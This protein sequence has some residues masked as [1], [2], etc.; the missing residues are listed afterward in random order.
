MVA[1][2]HPFIFQFS[3]IHSTH[4]LQSLFFLIIKSN[5]NLLYVQDVH[6]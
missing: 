5:S 6:A 4:E 1:Y 2:L 3:L